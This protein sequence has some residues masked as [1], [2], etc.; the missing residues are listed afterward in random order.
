M[1]K[2]YQ[3]IRPPYLPPRLTV[4]TFKVEEG[5]TSQ[6]FGIH[7]FPDEGSSTVSYNT[8]ANDGSFWDRDLNTTG[9]NSPYDPSPNSGRSFWN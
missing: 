8:A 9:Q 4:V 3:L 2:Q 1:D 5:F 7:L 6:L